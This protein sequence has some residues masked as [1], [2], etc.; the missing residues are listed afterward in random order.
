MLIMNV[1][2]YTFP[3]AYRAA[4]D[5]Q[6]AQSAGPGA[7]PAACTPRWAL[8]EMEAIPEFDSA[9]CQGPAKR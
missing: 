5:L 4:Q 3:A 2:S 6:T 9:I 8:D 7:G 1:R